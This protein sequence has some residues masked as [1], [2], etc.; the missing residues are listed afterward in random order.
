MYDRLGALLRLGDFTS[1]AKSGL[2]DS[3]PVNDYLTRAIS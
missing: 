3:A 1:F 2:A